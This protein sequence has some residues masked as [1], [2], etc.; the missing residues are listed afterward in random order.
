MVFDFAVA[1]AISPAGGHIA[2][3]DQG[4]QVVVVNMEPKQMK[5]KAVAIAQE[6]QKRGLDT[7]TIEHGAVAF[8]PDSS[9]IAHTTGKGIRLRFTI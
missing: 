4:E 8:A 9:I 1:L 7:F 6:A 2:I 3:I 5:V